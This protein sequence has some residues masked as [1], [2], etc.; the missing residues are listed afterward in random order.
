MSMT[1]TTITTFKVADGR[2]APPEEF[3]TL[4]EAKAYCDRYRESHDLDYGFIMRMEDG[5]EVGDWGDYSF[6]NSH[7]DEW[8]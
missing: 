2:G 1:D 8:Q 6:Y 7:I 5:E 3:P 4:E